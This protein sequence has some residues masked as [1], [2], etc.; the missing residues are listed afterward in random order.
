MQT[1]GMAECE[2]GSP[3]SAPAAVQSEQTARAASAAAPAAEAPSSSVAEEQ[4]PE[5]LVP[6]RLL[7]AVN[8]QRPLCIFYSM[9][10]GCR[11]GAKCPQRQ[12]HCH[13]AY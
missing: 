3:Q 10:K 5:L 11:K 6:E 4:Q 9:R 13:S 12:L 8:A 2:P 7:R 1:A